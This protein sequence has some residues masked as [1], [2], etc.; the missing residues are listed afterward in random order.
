VVD[1]VPLVALEQRAAVDAGGR[2][3]VAVEDALDAVVAAVVVAGGVGNPEAEAERGE[4]GRDEGDG[5]QGRE[6]PHRCPLSLQLR[7][8]GLRAGVPS[9]NFLRTLSRQP[10]K[11]HGDGGSARSLETTSNGLCLSE[12]LTKAQ[13]RLA[14]V[15]PA[16]PGA[17][18]MTR[19]Y[20]FH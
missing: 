18:G 2:V 14:A 9:V 7:C 6:D 5:S 16:A 19:R 20:R 11:G 8:A 3:L 17:T 4:Q 10:G 13:A 12:I 15:V 1:D